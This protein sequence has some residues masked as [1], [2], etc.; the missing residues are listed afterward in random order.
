MTE[1]AVFRKNKIEI[2]EYDYTQDIQNRVLMSAFTPGDVEVLEEILY[3]SLKIPLTVLEKNLSLSQKKLLSTLEK[4]LATELFKIEGEFVLVD[5]EKRKYYEM[6]ILKFEEDFKP[7]MEYLQGLLKKVPIHVLPSWYSIP[8]SSNNIFESIVEKYLL[9]P[10]TFQRYLLDL[11]FTDPA[12]SGIMSALYQSPNYEIEADAMK[13]KFGLTQEEFEKHMLH[14]EFSFVA[15]VKYVRKDDAFVEVITPFHEWREYLL[16]VRA[17]EP[18]SIIDDEAIER[19]KA[20]DFAILE[21]MSAIAKLLAEKP[22]SYGREILDTIRKECPDFTDQDFEDHVEKLCDLNLAIREEGE[23]HCTSDTLEW[24][25]MD[26]RD[27]SIYIY[28]HPLNSLDDGDVPEELCTERTVREAEKS[29]CQVVNSGWVYLEEFL[30]GIYIP[31]YESQSIFLK[32]VGRNWKYQ[33]PEYSEGEREFFR[34]MIEQWLFE[35]GITAIG[36][37]EGKSCFCVTPFGQELFDNE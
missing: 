12:E 37:H 28:R 24:L 13:K 14:L 2:S 16:K 34:A 27:R 25:R 5:K 17:S 33:L 19:T 20:S 10:Q 8:R 31:L 4:L 26:L 1:T 23:V 18:S 30:D 21:E 15:C 7:G 9:T 22:I 6:Q 32:R 35:V 29:I 11:Q 3:S 36:T